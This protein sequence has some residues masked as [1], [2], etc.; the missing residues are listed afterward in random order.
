MQILQISL[1]LFRRTSPSKGGRVQVI[2]LTES[3]FGKEFLRPPKFKH[4]DSK[5][6]KS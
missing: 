6:D 3:G 4:E 5:T 2:T 1:R